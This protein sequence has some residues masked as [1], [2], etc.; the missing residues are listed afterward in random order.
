MRDTKAKIRVAY[1]KGVE[2]RENMERKMLCQMTQIQ[3]LW[4]AL[5]I[6]NHFLQK[7][8]ILSLIDHILPTAKS[9]SLSTIFNDLIKWAKVGYILRDLCFIFMISLVTEVI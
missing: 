6:Y 2:H 9:K 7:Q 4:D 1:C 3:F 5:Y 8:D